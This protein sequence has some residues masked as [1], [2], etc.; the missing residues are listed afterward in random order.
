MECG[1][2][3][4]AEPLDELTAKLPAS[5]LP[6]DETPRQL[7]LGVTLL[8]DHGQ[9]EVL[10]DTLAE[11][12]AEE[13]QD[14]RFLLQGSTA[15]GFALRPEDEDFACILTPWASLPPQLLPPEQSPLS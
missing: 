9:R 5:C 7:G 3:T 6:E 4:F 8:L 12:S 13:N 2:L 11:W 15:E 14:C 1:S 10:L